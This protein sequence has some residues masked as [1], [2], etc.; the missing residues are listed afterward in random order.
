MFL[1]LVRDISPLLKVQALF[2]TWC[3]IGRHNKPHN[4]HVLFISAHTIS[5]TSNLFDMVSKHFL[6]GDNGNG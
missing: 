6:I 2:I 5:I 3:D 4:S 1:L